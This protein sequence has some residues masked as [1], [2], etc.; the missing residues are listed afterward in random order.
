MT[1]THWQLHQDNVFTV[2]CGSY[3]SLLSNY[4]YQPYCFKEMLFDVA[5]A[6]SVYLVG[7]VDASLSTPPDVVC[8]SQVFALYACFCYS[9]VLQF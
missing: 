6:L 9:Q 1:Q 8:A 5:I 7:G 4:L 3:I 2:L